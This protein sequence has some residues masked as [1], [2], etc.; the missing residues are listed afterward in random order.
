M[1][2]QNLNIFGKIFLV[3]KRIIYFWIAQIQKSTITGKK[4]TITVKNVKQPVF[5][6]EIITWKNHRQVCY[7]LHEAEAAPACTDRE[8]A[9][10]WTCV[11]SGAIVGL[12]SLG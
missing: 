1:F 3:N 4:E 8:A 7:G 11:C 9:A 2:I 6:D 12:C 5:Q 10:G